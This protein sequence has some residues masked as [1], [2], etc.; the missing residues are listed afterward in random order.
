[1]QQDEIQ[2]RSDAQQRQRENK[3]CKDGQVRRKQQTCERTVKRSGTKSAN[4]SMPAP[5]GDKWEQRGLIR[6]S[7]RVIG[8]VQRIV[9]SRECASLH[10]FILSHSSISRHTIAPKWNVRWRHETAREDKWRRRERENKA[11]SL[12]SALSPHLCCH[13]LRWESYGVRGREI[14]RV[15]GRGG[16]RVLRA[17]CVTEMTS[18]V[19]GMLSYK[20]LSVTSGSTNCVCVW[21]SLCVSVCVPLYT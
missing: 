20:W 8:S 6:C 7:A 19:N 18:S 17:E 16:R 15:G 2:Q 11:R 9:T 5:R 1:M 13:L 21:V 3:T 4:S 10:L 14:I 12:I